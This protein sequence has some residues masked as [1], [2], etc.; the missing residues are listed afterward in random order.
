MTT[1]LPELGS[2]ERQLI[3]N[4]AR[5]EP[6]S[7]LV[8]K[9]Q[10][11]LRKPLDWEAIL[12]YAKLHSV[13]PLLYRNLKFFDSLGHIPREAKRNF[14]RL[15]HR[16]E[17]QNQLLSNELNE[18]LK[19]FSESEVP[20]IVP[21]G[22]SLVEL[23]YRH[24]NLRPLIDLVLLIPKRKLEEA[25]RVLME[26]G[27][28]IRLQDP[29]QGSLFSQIHIE[30]RTDSVIHL[31]LQWNIV[32]WPMIHTIDLPKFWEEADPVRLSGRQTLI[33]SPIDL[34]LYLCFQPYK[35]CFLNAIAID[36]KVPERLVF[37]EWTNNRLIRFIDIYEVVRHYQNKLDWNLLIER[38]RDS[39]VQ[40]SVYTSLK[41]VTK[42]MGQVA[43]PWVLDALFPPSPQRRHRWFFEAI[44]QQSNGRV[45]TLTPKGV[46][47]Y[48]WLKKRKWQ[49]LRMIQFIK[50][51]EFMLP[52]LDEIK[53][54]YR[55]SS[56]RIAVAYY[57]YHVVKTVFFCLLP[58]MYRV[59]I[60]GRFLNT[61]SYKKSVKK[62]ART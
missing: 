33:P 42:L 4:F 26:K 27:Y 37:A 15:A 59:L 20:V 32:N 34:V 10:T 40:E 35:Q 16:T 39:G 46:F 49:Q 19:S 62:L 45:L 14:L 18:I 36:D 8:Q 47:G 57:P 38:A 55:L 29:N 6:E 51:L 61:Y 44:V 22:I 48:W 25:K 31:L 43:A 17:Y 58:W 53:V 2:D 60:K 41:W 13:A 54:L 56:N 50:L 21:K 7:L 28:T 30:K 5:L 52:S 1:N 24:L 12:F 11:I 9:T 3:L 23:I